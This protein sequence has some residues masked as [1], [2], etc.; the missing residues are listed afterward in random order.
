MDIVEGFRYVKGE[1]VEYDTM[2]RFVVRGISVEITAWTI[3]EALGIEGTRNPGPFKT[4]KVFD[5]KYAIAYGLTKT[6]SVQ[7]GPM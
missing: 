1:K 4:I 3:K 5:V 7:M 2:I 6:T